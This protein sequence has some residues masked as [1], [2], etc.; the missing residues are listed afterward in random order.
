MQEAGLCGGVGFRKAKA[1]DGVLEYK[2]T[3]GQS[4]PTRT[5]EGF[6]LNQQK[7][8]KYKQDLD[9]AK[10]RLSRLNQY[11]EPEPDLAQESQKNEGIRNSNNKGGSKIDWAAINEKLPTSK[12]QVEERNTLWGQIDANGN[13]FA[14][15]AEVDKGIRDGL[16]LS[17]I[18]DAKPSIIRAYQ[19]AKNYSPVKGSKN[20]RGDNY[21]EK[22]ELRV[23]LIALRQRFEY[24]EAFKKIDTGGDGR[25]NLREFKNAEL[26]IEKWV[27]PIQ[28]E[29]EF[30]TIDKNKGGFILFD[31]FC[32]WSI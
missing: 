20:T 32:E 28:S 1:G 5:V 23:F 26:L 30:S 11:E 18:F 29:V 16:E 8:L 7:L 19:Y 27:G 14:S 12:D 6:I 9:D 31:E 3:D 10:I 21:L 15:L 24:F 22:K 2:G 25:I 17:E 13:G 4:F